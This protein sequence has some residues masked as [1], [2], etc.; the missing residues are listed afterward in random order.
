MGSNRT[1]KCNKVQTASVK[2]HTPCFKMGNSQVNVTQKDS[3][4]FTETESLFLFLPLFFSKAKQEGRLSLDA[5]FSF[6]HL[7]KTHNLRGEKTTPILDV[8]CVYKVR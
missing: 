8:T 2:E 6:F 4:D 3:T 1:S 7:S 5:I